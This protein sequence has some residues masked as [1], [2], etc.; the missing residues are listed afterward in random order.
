[1]GETVREQIIEII[2]REAMVDVDALK[3]ETTLED[4]GVDSMGVVEAIFKI[5][6]AFG[7]TIPF[8]AN[9]REGFDFSSVGA[10]VNGVERLVARA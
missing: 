2:A 9:T 7:I 1:M 3:M 8:N 6:E 4:L 10:I 5:E